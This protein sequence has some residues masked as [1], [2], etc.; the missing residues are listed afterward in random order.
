MTYSLTYISTI[1]LFLTFLCKVLGYEVG[2]EQ[3]TTTVEVIVGL[4]AAIGA[5][6]GR[7]RVGGLKFSGVRK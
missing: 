4:I 7:Y 2:T 3:L 6:Y 5:L 1:V